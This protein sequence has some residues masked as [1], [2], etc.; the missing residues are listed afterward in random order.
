MERIAKSCQKIQQREIS[1]SVKNAE[2]K[3][4][5]YVAQHSSIKT[6][7][8]LGELLPKLDSTTSFQN[9]KVHRTKCTMLIKNVIG[10]SLHED[11]ILEIGNSS[12]SL[13]IDESTDLT[14]T[15]QLCI[16]I[17]YFS[18]SKNDCVTT[19]YCLLELTS[20]D[21]QTIYDTIKNKLKTDGLKLEHLIGI[22]VDGASVMVGVHN[23]LSV[24]LKRDVPDIIVVKCVC[25]SLHLCAEKSSEV[26]PRQLE[27]LIRE[28]HNWFSYSPKRLAQ[29]RELYRT[30]N[31]NCTPKKIQGLCGTRWLARFT[32]IETILEQWDELKLLFSLAKNEDKCYMA[33]QLYN[34]MDCPAYKAFLIFLRNELKSIC[35]VNVIFQSDNIEP[36]KV[37]EDLFLLFKSVL[38]KI[39]VPSQLDQQKDSDLT[40]FNFQN[41]VIHTSAI[42]LGYDFEC[43]TKEFLKPEESADVRERCKKFLIVLCSELQKRI[44]ENISILKMITVFHPSSAT[45]QQKPDIL[46]IVSNFSRYKLNGTADDIVSEWNNLQNKLWKNTSE[47]TSFWA[48]VLSDKDAAGNARFGNIAN[49]AIGM[50]SLPIS[51]STVERAFSVFNVIK[52]K[53][54]NRLSLELTNSLLTIRYYLKT[55]KICCTNFQPSGKML[56]KFNV[57]MYDQK[58]MEL[59]DEESAILEDL[60]GLEAA[61]SADF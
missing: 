34:I 29:Y 32:A 8:H 15:K 27:F 25:H 49:F 22:G 23:S 39:V 55:E 30:I 13:I 28:V 43:Y 47:T 57:S 21:A 11:L 42:Y 60:G 45:S 51:N 31:E 16:M 40:R 6:V 35:R 54:R 41:Y 10:S 19:F 1:N 17:R 37:L 24:L 7:D 59:S 20:S 52:N 36:L 18:I 46:P 26:L 4:A 53:L 58:R 48:E 38:K 14:T 2:L 33:E 44:P 9:L 50:L 5:V 61:C 56:T 3:I 12:Y